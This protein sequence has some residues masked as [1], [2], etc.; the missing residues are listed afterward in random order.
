[1]LFEVA[2]AR[3]LVIRSSISGKRRPRGV[4]SL[5]SA[6]K[7]AYYW[8][9]TMIDFNGLVDSFYAALYRFALSLS[10]KES[11]AADFVQQTFYIWALKGHQLREE[12][13]VKTWL[14]MTLYRE[15]LA[16]RRH[17]DRFIDIVDGN[18]ILAPPPLRPPPAVDALDAATVQDALHQ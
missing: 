8:T 14:F 17:D 13:K 15:F 1:E 16:R 18:T 12:S 3:Y 4:Y 2:H 5:A 10:R 9:I 6:A 11:D 7:Y